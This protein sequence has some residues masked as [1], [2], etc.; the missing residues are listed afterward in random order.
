MST[1]TP[2]LTW[3]FSQTATFAPEPAPR[4]FPDVDLTKR[5]AEILY[6]VQEGKSSSDIGGILGLSHRTVEHHLENVCRRFGVRTRIQ[7]VLKA[8]D[9]GLIQ[10]N[11][12]GAYP[13]TLGN[14]PR[15]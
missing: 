2:R 12:G 15:I 6:W 1:R 9:M 4:S 13:R 3:S 5:Q 7:A 14:P 11:D 8:R 10:A